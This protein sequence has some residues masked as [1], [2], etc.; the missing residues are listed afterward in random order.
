MNYDRARQDVA[1]DHRDLRGVQHPPHAQAGVDGISHPPH[2]LWPARE[3]WPCPAGHLAYFAG[4]FSKVALQ[5]AE[6]K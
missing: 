1:Q 3:A 4:A 6:Q 5:T 2:V